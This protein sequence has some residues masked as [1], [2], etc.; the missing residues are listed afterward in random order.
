MRSS[1]APLVVNEGLREGG[2]A[3]AAAAKNGVEAVSVYNMATSL[4]S[5]SLSFPAAPSYSL[6][7]SPFCTL[8]PT[9]LRSRGVCFIYVMLRFFFVVFFAAFLQLFSCSRIGSLGLR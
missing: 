9:I 5:L 7:N 3:A 4:L 6:L 1:V 2:Q 8:K